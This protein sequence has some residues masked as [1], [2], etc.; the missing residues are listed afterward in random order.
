MDTRSVQEIILARLSMFL[1]PNTARVA[2]KTFAART[3][4]TPDA[5]TRADVPAV[6]AALLPMLRTLI[7]RERADGLVRQL[8]QEIE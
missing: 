3:G 2:L 6:L 8:D 5:L 4:R 7:G 1:G